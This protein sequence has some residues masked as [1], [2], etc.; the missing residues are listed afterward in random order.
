MVVGKN[1]F[2]PLFLY[3][4]QGTWL[5]EEA[6][7]LTHLWTITLSKYCSDP[8]VSSE[9][10]IASGISSMLTVFFVG[11]YVIFLYNLLA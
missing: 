1:L 2:T 10:K 6:I 3:T 11:K 4:N 8:T 9:G 7:R 5:A